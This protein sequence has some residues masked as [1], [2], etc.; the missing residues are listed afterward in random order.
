[1]YKRE[2][3][4][5]PVATVGIGARVV[6]VITAEPCMRTRGDQRGRIE[7]DPDQLCFNTLKLRNSSLLFDYSSLLLGRIIPCKFRGADFNMSP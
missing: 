3:L 1:M 5:L 6:Q 4:D 2:L 7:W